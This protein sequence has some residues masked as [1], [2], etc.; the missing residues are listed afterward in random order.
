MLA[1]GKPPPFRRPPEGVADQH[2]MLDR[3]SLRRFETQVSKLPALA[4]RQVE[5]GVFRQCQKGSGVASLSTPF[6]SLSSFRYRFIPVPLQD[7]DKRHIQHT[8]FYLLIAA[9]KH[10]KKKRH[11]FWCLFLVIN[12]FS[13]PDIENNDFDLLIINIGKDSIASYPISPIRF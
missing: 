4:G 3:L 8:V 1:H 6:R 13:V 10:R 2:G 11:L 9:K 12:I 7:V 5:K